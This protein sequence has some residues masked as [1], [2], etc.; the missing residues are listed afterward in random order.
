MVCKWFIKQN[1]CEKILSATFP[2]MLAKTKM[3]FTNLVSKVLFWKEV[4]KNKVWMRKLYLSNEK[5]FEIIF[6]TSF[7][8]KKKRGSNSLSSKQKWV[9]KSFDLKSFKRKVFWFRKQKLSKDFVSKTC[10]DFNMFFKSFATHPPS[11][12]K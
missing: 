3:S 6:K 12:F 4:S 2:K 8:F 9:S 5:W 11:S 7:I 10:M 1:P